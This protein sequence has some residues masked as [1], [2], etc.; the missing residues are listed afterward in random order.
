MDGQNRTD[1]GYV[2]KRG[3]ESV[4]RDYPNPSWWSLQPRAVRALIRFVSVFGTLTLTTLW[5]ADRR[6]FWIVVGCIAGI[7]LAYLLWLAWGAVSNYQERKHTIIPFTQAV[8]PILGMPPG[9]VERT[10]Q[11]TP[12]QIRIEV[13]A[14]FNPHER[15]L[16]ELTSLANRRLTGE[17][18]AASQVRKLPFYVMLTKQA[19]PRKSFSFD[20]LSL[21][22]DQQQPG[23][24]IL[25]M[26]THDRLITAN[27][28]KEYPMVGLSMGTGAGKSSFF[29]SMIAQ[30]YYH[31]FQ[32]WDIFDVKLISLAGLDVLPGVNIYRTPEEIRKAVYQL[33][34]EM[35]RRN[36]EMLANPKKV[37]K[38]KYVVMEEQNAFAI[39]TQIDWEQ[40]GGKKKDTVWQDLKVLF[41]MARQVQIYILS[42][43]QFLTA[44]ASGGDSTIRTQMGL[45]IL[46]RFSPQAWDML[47]GERPRERSSSHP[48]RC[49]AVME[50]HRHH[51]QVPYLT[52]E[53]ALELAHLGLDRADGTAKK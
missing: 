31:G 45:K 7:L 27:I 50:G 18:T 1:A 12:E 11:F 48:G 49:V 23:N 42:A 43:Y 44:A 3:L 33:R 26:G 37:F 32:D 16:S 38:P 41:V 20:E 36:N 4:Q 21:L 24:F 15:E 13:P 28:P 39:L 9:R 19:E 6:R 17:W 35:E 51:F 29:R 8:A 2:W 52:L 22:I 25:G 46:G 40:G 14:H 30:G 53:N 34:L 47:V 5:V 10:M